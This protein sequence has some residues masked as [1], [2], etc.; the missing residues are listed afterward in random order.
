[1]R[2]A[3]LTLSAQIASTWYQL[4]EAGGQIEILEAQIGT[5]EQILDLV[6]LGFRR[7]QVGASDVLRQRQ[8]VESGRGELHLARARESVLT[9]QLSVLVGR[10]PQD[11]VDPSDAGLID[12]P[13][14]PRTGLPS[15]LLQRRPDLRAAHLE[16]AAASARLGQAVAERY[17]RINLS[18]DI[19]TGGAETSSLFADWLGNLAAG[20]VMPVLD[21]NSRK[22]ETDRQEA[23]LREA[24]DRYRHAILTAL[25]EV[26][27]AL[28]EESRQREYLE[29][30]NTQL[31]LANLVLDRTRD[32]YVSGQADYLRVLEALT[33]QQSLERRQLSA[34][35]DLIRYRIELCRALGGSWTPK[36]PAEGATS[37]GRKP[38]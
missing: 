11:P 16:I 26:E 9:H 36:R 19:G 27:N 38:S 6:T 37:S 29:S 5:N 2:A 34:R 14:L 23:S 25:E 30:L 35:R 32:A 24:V 15:E 33:S 3:A 10:T 4:A 7:G 18:G 21:G 12:L 1:V 13:P 31:E 8:L 20:I 28:A 17:P 22:A